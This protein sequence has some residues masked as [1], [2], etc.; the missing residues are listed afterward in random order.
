M[1]ASEQEIFKGKQEENLK[2]IV[3]VNFLLNEN[4]KILWS[5]KCSFG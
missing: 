3:T 4:D 2:P 1:Q 5:D